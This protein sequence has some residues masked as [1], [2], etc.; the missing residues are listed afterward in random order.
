MADRTLVLYGRTGTYKTANAGFIAQYIYEKYQ[1]KTR[2]VYADGGSFAHLKP[3]INLGIIEPFVMVDD[4]D[5]MSIIKAIT[6]DKLWPTQLDEHF[7]RTGGK[8][9]KDMTG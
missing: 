6:I 5:P 7:K 2:Y 8:A 1:L 9:T 4:P 3:L